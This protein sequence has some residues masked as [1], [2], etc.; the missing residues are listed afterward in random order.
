MAKVPDGWM[1]WLRSDALNRDED[2]SK[3]GGMQD[4]APF[5]GCV[6]P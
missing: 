1:A 3:Q 6:K 4:L 5:R 2:P